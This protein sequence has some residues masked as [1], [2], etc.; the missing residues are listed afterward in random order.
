MHPCISFNFKILIKE[1][2]IVI[3]RLKCAT[4]AGIAMMV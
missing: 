1:K 4:M 3:S 2:K